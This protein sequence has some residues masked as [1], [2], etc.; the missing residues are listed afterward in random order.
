MNCMNSMFPCAITI[1]IIAFVLAK[2]WCMQ[3][4]NRLWKIN[5]LWE[6]KKI[7]YW[8][9]KGVGIYLNNNNNRLI[10]VLKII[11]LPNSN[12]TTFEGIAQ[13]QVSRPWQAI[14]GEL[15]LGLFY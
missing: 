12:V 14:C 15:I 10:I 3:S 6:K 13:I 1:Q 7:A 11:H 9:E 2:T 4:R 8:R 5:L